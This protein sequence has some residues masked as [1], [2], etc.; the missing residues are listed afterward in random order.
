M[1][2]IPEDAGHELADP[3]I[4]LGQQDI[5]HQRSRSPLLPRSGIEAHIRLE[6]VNGAE[7][8]AQ[9]SARRAAQKSMD[10]GRKPDGK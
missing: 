6:K 2:A 8:F 7:K 1:P 5:C 3:A 9:K 10:I 4:R